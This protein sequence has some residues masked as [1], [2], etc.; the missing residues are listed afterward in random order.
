[1]R[2]LRILSLQATLASEQMVVRRTCQVPR[3][4]LGLLYRLGFPNH[5]RLVVV[6]RP[7][8][9]PFH[10]W[11]LFPVLPS[12]RKHVNAATARSQLAD[13][14][15]HHLVL[16]A[17]VWTDELLDGRGR[18][19]RRG[20]RQ[21]TE[22]VRAHQ[23]SR[24]DAGRTRVRA[25][26]GGVRR[27]QEGRVGQLGQYVRRVVSYGRLEERP[28]CANLGGCSVGARQRTRVRPC[29]HG[30]DATSTRTRHDRVVHWRRL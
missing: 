21:E 1:M 9:E 15:A 30:S 3:V 22:R 24:S 28:R 8:R 7:A 4:S 16:V 20:A 13:V 19:W 12:T 2:A 10:L 18:R 5:A 23:G 27:T 6:Q 25:V 26:D 11:T 29:W 14:P 17:K